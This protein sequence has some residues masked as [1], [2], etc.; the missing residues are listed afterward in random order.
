MFF[1]LLVRDL[2]SRFIGSYTG[3][4]WLLIN[5]L[6]LLG[7]YALVF[8]VIFQA[9]VP[10]GLDVAFVVW[11]AIGL[12]PWLAFSE[13]IVRASESM[14]QHSNLISKVAL[15]RELLTL[16]VATSAFLLQLL[17]YFVVLLSVSL[18]GAPIHLS[19]LP[20]ALVIL[21][22][23]YILACGF[24][25]IAAALRVFFRDLEQLLPTL[26]MFGFFLT[27]ILYSPQ[28][29]P[30][31]LQKWIMLNPIAGLLVDSRVALLEG[32]VWPSWTTAVMLLAAIVIFVFAKMLFNRLSPYF[33][34]F[35]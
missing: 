2:R 35:L 7:A 1:D 27:P 16:S 17:G 30:E 9:R 25:M 14:P 23:L 34:D 29:L 4:L 31:N 24:G 20:H 13:S 5:P 28:M 11:L 22:V 19:G 32:K 21:L 15:P 26:L 10:A 6:L 18:M 8:G 12:W 3:W 33:E